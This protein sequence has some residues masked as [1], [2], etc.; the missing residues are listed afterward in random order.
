MKLKKIISLCKARKQITLFSDGARDQQWL[1]DGYAVY[2]LDDILCLDTAALCRLYDINDNQQEK[3]SL[4]DFLTLPEGLCFYDNENEESE[5]QE[6]DL[7]ICYNGGILVPFMTEEGIYYIEKKYL[8][9]L[10]D[11]SS[12]TWL[13]TLR[14]DSAGRPVIAVKIGLFLVA[15]ILTYK[16]PE[17]FIDKLET[18]YKQS[19]LSI[20]LNNKRENDAV[21][22]TSAP[23]RS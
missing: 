5:A 11:N 18:L 19:R 2:L 13:F 4:N 10:T 16:M 7:S 21:P 22:E 9:P 3:I 6:L 8:E 12:D 23:D 17:L 1:T 20:Q 14:H 15:I